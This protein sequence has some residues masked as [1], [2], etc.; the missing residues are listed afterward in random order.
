MMAPSRSTIDP[1]PDSNQIGVI[2]SS[3]QMDTLVSAQEVSIPAV[4]NRRFTPQS[5]G[6]GNP[7]SSASR[8]CTTI[9]AAFEPAATAPAACG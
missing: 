3:S 6:Y 5:G 7:N 8:L 4:D 9:I 1:D 2:V